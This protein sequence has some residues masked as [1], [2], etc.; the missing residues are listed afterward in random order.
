MFTEPNT[1]KHGAFDKQIVVFSFRQLSSKTVN[2]NSDV[3]T[4][5]G[6]LSTVD[7][8]NGQSYSYTLLD[9]AGGRFKIQRN[10]VK[11]NDTLS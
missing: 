8:D 10:F 9:S 11:V 6:M 5:V 4:V 1:L 7:P 2:E 3:D